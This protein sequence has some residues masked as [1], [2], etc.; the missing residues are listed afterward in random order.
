MPQLNE[1]EKYFKAKFASTEIQEKI[2]LCETILSGNIQ[3]QCDVALVTDIY[4][5]SHVISEC[6]DTTTN[7]NDLSAA[8]QFLKNCLT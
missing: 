7:P 3:Q 2:A 1:I 8:L 6:D 5:I 4:M